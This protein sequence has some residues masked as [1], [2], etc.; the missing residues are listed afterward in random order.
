MNSEVTLDNT[1]WYVLHTKPN[2]EDRAASNLTAWQVETFSPR[3]KVRTYNSYTGKI[4]YLSKPLFP[5]YIFARFDLEKMLHK[6]R[7]TRGV[8]KV[9]TVGGVPAP[10]SDE[11]IEHIQSQMG[12]DGY[13]RIGEKL[14]PGD[15][16]KIKH[17]PLKDL[18]GIFQ[19]ETKDSERVLILL[20]SI[21]FQGR[22]TVDREMVAKVSA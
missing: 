19:T 17:G 11:I 6:I 22:V 12:E 1:R 8:N 4:T 21:S 9:V 13:V 5:Q 15:P 20:T 16:V 7:F 10:V 18:V 2:N 14:K 3:M